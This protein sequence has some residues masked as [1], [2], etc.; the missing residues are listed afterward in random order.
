MME[1][2]TMR[3][4]DLFRRIRNAHLAMV[5]SLGTS[6]SPEGLLNT[7]MKM[8]KNIL[9][10]K[11]CGI[12]V[13]DRGG[14][15][16]ESF[17]GIKRRAIERDGFCSRGRL[18]SYEIKGDMKAVLYLTRK[19]LSRHE[20]RLV[21]EIV[22]RLGPALRKAMEWERQ[23]QRLSNL[24]REVR[25]RFGRANI[26]GKSKPMRRL[27]V[28]LEK[29]IPTDLPALIVGETGTGKELIAKVLHYEGPRS[30]EPFVPINCAALP[31]TLLESELFGYERGAFTGA[32][33]AK[34]GLFE[35]ANGGTLFLDEVGSL[36]LQLQAKLL[37][38]LETGEVR[39]LGATTLRKVNV[40]LIAASNTPLEKMVSEGR[41]RAD[42]FYRLN[43]VSI[44]VPPLRDRREDI[45]VLVEHFLQEFSSEFGD[46]EPKT[47]APEALKKLTLFDYPGNVR[48]LKHILLRA[49]VTSSHRI[50]PEDIVLP[51]PNEA[52]LTG[53]NFSLKELEK[54][55]IIAALSRAGGSITHAAKIL[56]IS[57]TTLYRKCRKMRIKS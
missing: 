13:T 32:T 51:E 33:D 42:L 50:E 23:R 34:P 36:P 22:L 29:I 7:V 26:V 2:G 17:V 18:F 27:F 53:E 3:I 54:R 19:A 55:A 9:G 48:E 38:I 28:L 4:A 45:P 44:R 5:E 15:K 37:R 16:C 30:S 39:R 49:Y 20:V 40:R 43:V 31:E 41:F 8:L 14:M 57:R 11:G 56:G 21:N 52:M 24:E 25:T 47:I 6:L 35:V 1:N 12:V 10:L 46:K